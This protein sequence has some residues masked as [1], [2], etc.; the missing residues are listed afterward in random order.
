MG[1]QSGVGLKIVDRV[2]LRSGVQD[3][4]GFPVRGRIPDS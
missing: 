3:R 1:F 2:P 4:D